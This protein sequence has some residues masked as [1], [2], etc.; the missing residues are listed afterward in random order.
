MILRDKSYIYHVV[1]CKER[2][3]FTVKSETYSGKTYEVDLLEDPY[4]CDCAD[5]HFRK[6]DCKHIQNCLL[7]LAYKTLDA[8]TEQ[9]E[10]H[11]H[12]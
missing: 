5:A 6:A 4:K 9:E 2:A 11:R 1:E 3:R 8:W 12:D 10:I 7:W